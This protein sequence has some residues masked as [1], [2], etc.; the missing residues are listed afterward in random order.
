[1]KGMCCNFDFLDDDMFSDNLKKSRKKSNTFNFP[2]RSRGNTNQ[3]AVSET[4]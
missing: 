4:E 3:A 1:M 2:S